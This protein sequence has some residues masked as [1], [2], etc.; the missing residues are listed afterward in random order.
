MIE[1]KPQK[2][3]KSATLTMRLTQQ[4][5]DALEAAAAAE[6]RSIS[7]MAERWL[8]LAANGEADLQGR[9]GGGALAETMVTAATFARRLSVEI[10]KAEPELAQVN[11]T[12]DIGLRAALVG[13]LGRLFALAYPIR[14]HGFAT[15]D[16]QPYRDALRQA[17]EQCK[18]ELSR[19]ASPAGAPQ[20]YDAFVC[21]DRCVVGD[22]AARALVD[23]DTALSRLALWKDI[24]LLE[25]AAAAHAA[26]Q[27][28]RRAIASEMA[29]LVEWTQRGRDFAE[30]I[31]GAELYART[32]EAVLRVQRE[33][34]ASPFATGGALRAGIVSTN[35]LIEREGAIERAVAARDSH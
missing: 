1:P 29:A 32:H 12:E 4:T 5:R 23:L 30:H 2:P 19:A 17:C 20:D 33:M 22:M 8:D 7:E 18:H 24:P 3:K 31:A 14:G 9:L 6:G 10:A 27:D 28:Y 16:P 15:P 35:A 34:P 26:M 13:G 11:F 21:L 25:S